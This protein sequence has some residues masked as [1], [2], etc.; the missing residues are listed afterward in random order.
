M[1]NIFESVPAF[2]KGVHYKELPPKDG[3]YK[4]RFVTLREIEFKTIV[5]LLPCYVKIEF[6][7][8]KGRVWM[9]IT[10]HT[11]TISKD[12]AWDGCTPKKWWGIWW[13]VPDF[14]S[15]NLA[16]LLHDALLQFHKT[17]HFQFKRKTIDEIFRLILDEC[18]F[19]LSDVYYYG[20]R[21]GNILPDKKYNV[22]SELTTIPYY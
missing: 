14:H 22:K 5:P 16:S 8:I 17:E 1:N 12:Y 6:K 18:D 15:T 9:T 7:D 10:N 2:E 11:I 21:I 20:V 19:L 13:G 4:Y 3:K